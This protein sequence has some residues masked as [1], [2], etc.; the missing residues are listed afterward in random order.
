MAAKYITPQGSSSET[1]YYT[2]RDAYRTDGFNRA[3]FSASY[4]HNISAGSRKVELF[5]Q[6]Q[7]LNILNEQDLCGC[8]AT[9]FANGG[10]IIA[11]RISGNTQNQSILTPVSS[12][13]MAKFNPFTTVP[14]KGV[15]W[16]TTA[17]FGTPLSRTA[18]T[19]PR[20]FRMNF[21]IRF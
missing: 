10:N 5:V 20:E 19:S 2:N 3:D 12:A 14:V 6:A 18:Y 8:G 17:T 11:T 15:N 9:V 4:N 1:Y 13:T 7:V 16:D 21:G